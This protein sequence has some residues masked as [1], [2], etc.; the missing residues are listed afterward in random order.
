MRLLLVLVLAFWP[1]AIIACSFDVDCEPGSTCLKASGSIYDVC[2]GG[3]FPGN[4]HDQQRN[5]D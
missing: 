2:I 4:D 5:S 3:L 1:S